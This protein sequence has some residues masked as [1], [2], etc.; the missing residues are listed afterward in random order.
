MFCD[1]EFF[2]FSPLIQCFFFFFHGDVYSLVAKSALRLD[3]KFFQN[4]VLVIGPSF[5]FLP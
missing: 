3:Q 4:L 5:G 1:L 2:F